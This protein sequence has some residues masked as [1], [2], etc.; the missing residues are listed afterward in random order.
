MDTKIGMDAGQDSGSPK[1][2]KSERKNISH[3]MLIV[4]F[5]KPS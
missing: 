5:G 2:A 4:S 1:K 3:G